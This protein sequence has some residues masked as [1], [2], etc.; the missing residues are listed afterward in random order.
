MRDWLG[1]SLLQSL[2]LRAHSLLFALFLLWVYI[3][4]FK[5]EAYGTEKFMDYAFITSMMPCS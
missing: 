3:I 5:P 2:C 1:Q 4:G